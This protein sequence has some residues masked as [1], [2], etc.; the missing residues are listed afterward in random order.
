M[1]SRKALRSQTDG[2]ANYHPSFSGGS[3][4]DNLTSW[5]TILE[6]KHKDLKAGRRFPSHTFL[7]H[8]DVLYAV[9]TCASPEPCVCCISAVCLSLRPLHAALPPEA[10]PTGSANP[11]LS[12][13]VLPEQR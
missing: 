11:D 10:L 2:E 8:R 3:R 6:K 5:E 9:R 1:C 12:A 13:G 4:N 7:G